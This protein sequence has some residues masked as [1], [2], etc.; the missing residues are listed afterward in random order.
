MMLAVI[1]M[2]A[3]ARHVVVVADMI[4][5]YDVQQC[6]TIAHTMPAN[7][8]HTRRQASPN[9]TT[10]HIQHNAHDA[11]MPVMDR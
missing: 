10:Q 6:L 3:A 1:V 11:H 2:S 5:K 4:P 8:Y 7:H 9:N